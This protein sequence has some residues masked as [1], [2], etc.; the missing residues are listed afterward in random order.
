MALE[1][2]AA[3]IAP[4]LK[5]DLPEMVKS[6]WLLWVPFQFINFRFVPANLQVGAG[7][8]RQCLQQTRLP[9]LQVPRDDVCAKRCACPMAG[10]HSE[11]R[12]GG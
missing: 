7:T 4:K 5:A 8:A 2:H 9:A 6:N 12:C 3:D 10:L 1:G 11:R